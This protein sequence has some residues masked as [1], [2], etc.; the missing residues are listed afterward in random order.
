MSQPRGIRIGAVALGV[1]IDK[2]TFIVLAGALAAVLV[3]NSTA[4][5]VF[6]LL[7]GTACTT[8]GAYV[9]AHRAATAFLTHGFLV[10]GVGFAISFAR[11]VTFSLNPPEHPGAV[12][13]LWW[14]MLS[15][16]LLAVAGVLGGSLAQRRAGES[17]A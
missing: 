7:L 8:L 3:T 1:L 10:A 12:H 15:W 14:E 5:S 16:S 4:F 17:A 9:A 13:P 2:G 11:Y 6:A